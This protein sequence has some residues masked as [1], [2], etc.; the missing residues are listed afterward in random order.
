MDRIDKV[1]LPDR[2]TG[3]VFI[4]YKTSYAASPRNW[5]SNRPDDPQLPLYSLTAAPGELQA[6]AFAKIRAGQQA[7]WTGY[8]STPGIL[9]FKA[10]S[11]LPQKV[12]A[13]RDTLT[14]LAHAFYSGDASVSPK[15]FAQNCKN[16]VQRLVCRLNLDD[17]QLDLADDEDGA[18]DD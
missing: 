3:F 17:L 2:E 10:I 13:W 12:D 14:Q 15:D 18:A 5:E 9:P 1:E 4:D 7:E 6:I 11:D 8:Q 16:C